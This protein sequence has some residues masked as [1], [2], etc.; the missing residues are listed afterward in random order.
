M[1]TFLNGKKYEYLPLG[2]YIRLFHVAIR[3]VMIH[4]LVAHGNAYY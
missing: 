2:S 4:V 3:A 1:F